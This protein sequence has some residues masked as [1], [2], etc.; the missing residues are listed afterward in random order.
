MWFS[1]SEVV[2]HLNLQILERKKRMFLR[3]VDE[4]GLD[5]DPKYPHCH[6]R[7]RFL[8]LTFGFIHISS[9]D[10]G[11]VDRLIFYLAFNII[12][13]ISLRQLTLVLSFLKLLYITICQRER[14]LAKHPNEL[15][16]RFVHSGTIG[17][18]F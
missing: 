1:Q 15:F 12:S 13:V 10:S 14:Y 6:I 8:A 16:R 9:S 7:T 18:F 4:Y 3:M 2:L 5:P 11:G 17:F